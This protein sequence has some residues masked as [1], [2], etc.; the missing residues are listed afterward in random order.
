MVERST[1]TPHFFASISPTAWWFAGASILSCWQQS[2]QDWKSKCWGLCRGLLWSSS[3]SP[4][5]PCMY[6]AK[7]QDTRALDWWILFLENDHCMETVVHYLSLGLLLCHWPLPSV[8]CWFPL[9]SPA[10]RS[11]VPLVSLPAP[12]PFCSTSSLDSLFWSP[13]SE[14]YPW[15]QPGPLLCIS[16]SCYICQLMM[17]PSGCIIRQLQLTSQDWSRSCPKPAPPQPAPPQ[18]VATPSF[19]LLRQIPQGS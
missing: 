1:H 5:S 9:V 2:R 3:G 14:Y 13:G 11:W 17:S 19:W 16:N 8:L 7:E 12:V 10:T 15:R 4:D 18:L 6:S